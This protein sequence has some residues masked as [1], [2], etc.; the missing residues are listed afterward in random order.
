MLDKFCEYAILAEECFIT[1]IYKCVTIHA[2]QEW[3]DD[4][5]PPLIN[6]ARL[7]PKNKDEG[8]KGS[9]KDGRMTMI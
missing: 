9:R 2:Y 4:E 7:S 6:N 5:A 1:P 8:P 3:C